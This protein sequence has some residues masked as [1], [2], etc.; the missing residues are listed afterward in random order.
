MRKIVGRIRVA[1]PHDLFTLKYATQ[2]NLHEVDLFCSIRIVWQYHK[3]LTDLSSATLVFRS[4]FMLRF[5]GF[6]LRCTEQLIP[7]ELDDIHDWPT[8]FLFYSII[9]G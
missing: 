2:L 3:K 7:V 5:L 1:C 9:R 4:T 8:Y 6:E